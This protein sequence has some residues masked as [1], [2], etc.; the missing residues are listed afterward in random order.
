MAEIGNMI[1]GNA[2]T[3][4]EERLGPLGLSVPTVIFGRNYQARSSRVLQWSVIPF[5]CSG[6]ELDVR[7][8]LVKTPP[9]AHPKT[10]RPDAISV[11]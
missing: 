4:F 11:G 1:I 7:F 3:A 8:S 2:K 10:L 9:A 5:H 6:E